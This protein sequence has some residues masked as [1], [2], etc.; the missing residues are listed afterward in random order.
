MKARSRLTDNQL[1]STL[2][3]LRV[4]PAP[5][6]SCGVSVISCVIQCVTCQNNRNDRF[7]KMKSG[8]G[9]VIKESIGVFVPAQTDRQV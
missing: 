1:Q 6:D 4:T 8:V 5:L 9:E 3:T 7:S 2:L